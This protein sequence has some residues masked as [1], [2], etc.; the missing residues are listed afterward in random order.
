MNYPSYDVAVSKNKSRYEFI[1]V[2]RKGHI[3]KI[4]E[5]SYLDGLNLW[6]LGFGD[7]D[8]IRNKIDDE[9][10]SDNGDGRKVIKTV[11]LTLVQF[12]EEYPKET[13]IFMGSDSRRALLYNRIV[14]QFYNEFSGKL[15]ISG[16]SQEGI[17]VDIETGKQYIAFIIR[18]SS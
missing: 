5:Y 6:N 11:A 16:W 3:R 1:S 8:P 4:V 17:E 10:I 9:V 2:G 14:S 7:F 12:L 13:V 15:L 18:K